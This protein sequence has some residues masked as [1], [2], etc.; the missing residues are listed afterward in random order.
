MHINITLFY[1]IDMSLYKIY[2]K[3]LPVRQSCPPHPCSHVQIP[4]AVHLLFK[5]QPPVQIATETYN[6]IIILETISNG[7]FFCSIQLEKCRALWGEPEQAVFV[8]KGI[9]VITV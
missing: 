5:P 7:N 9:P 8:L 2:S 4:G 6:T 3:S 1:G